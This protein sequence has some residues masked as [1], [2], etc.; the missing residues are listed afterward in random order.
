[1]LGCPCHQRPISRRDVVGWCDYSNLVDVGTRLRRQ[2]FQVVVVHD[3]SGQIRA[4]VNLET[5]E[6]AVK[7]GGAFP[8]GPAA[9]KCDGNPRASQCRVAF[10][11]AWFRCRLAFDPAWFTCF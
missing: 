6:V 7:L 3:V 2:H 9:V 4:P 5:V 11:P 10:D 1:M 8:N